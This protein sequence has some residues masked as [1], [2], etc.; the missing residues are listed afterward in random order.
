MNKSIETIYNLK[1]NYSILALTGLEG[2]GCTYLSGLMSMDKNDFLKS[3]R[4]RNPDTF[5]VTEKAGSLNN[6]VNFKN[7]TSNNEVANQ[8]I[9][10]RKYAICYSFFEEHYIPYTVIKYTK[11]CWLYTLLF[12]R[13]CA[14]SDKSY[15]RKF[16]KDKLLEIFLDKFV[17]SKTSPDGDKDY[18]ESHPNRSIS[19]MEKMVDSFTF[20][21]IENEINGLYYEGFRKPRGENA[22]KISDVFF[23]FISLISTR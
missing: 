11:A 20:G 15:T 21:S 14:G 9:F 4:L 19:E 16:L 7:N 22:D 1:K 23:S 5:T 3:D 8:L 2:S 10:H 13:E 17:S 6:A 18:C 12:L